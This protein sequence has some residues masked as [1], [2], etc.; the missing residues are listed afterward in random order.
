MSTLQTSRIH[1]TSAKQFRA[2]T[3]SHDD[4]LQILQSMLADRDW[5]CASST[6]VKLHQILAATKGA[7]HADESAW[8]VFAEEIGRYLEHRRGCLLEALLADLP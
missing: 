4:R 6:Q 3:A 1:L 2:T 7:Q 5:H 8:I